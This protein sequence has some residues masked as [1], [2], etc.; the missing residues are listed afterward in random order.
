MVAVYV[1]ACEGRLGLLAFHKGLECEALLVSLPV[2]RRKRSASFQA[3][4]NKQSFA[5]SSTLAF[6]V[7]AN[8]LCFNHYMTTTAPSYPLCCTSTDACASGSMGLSV[9]CGKPP[10]RQLETNWKR[11]I[12]YL[13]QAIR[14]H[15]HIYVKSNQ[16]YF[17]H[18]ASP[19]RDL[20]ARL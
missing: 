17:H 13:A 1:C 8:V 4:R 12:A 15:Q 18:L 3:I 6:Y 7:V 5:A 11:S 10:F 2:R 19:G 14:L 16:Y 20:F 9:H